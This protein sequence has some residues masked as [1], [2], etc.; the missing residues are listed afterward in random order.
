MSEPVALDPSTPRSK[1]TGRMTPLR[2]RNLAK[3]R[4]RAASPATKSVTKAEPLKL[5]KSESKEPASESSTALPKTLDSKAGNDTKPQLPD[6]RGAPSRLSSRR[7]QIVIQRLSAKKAGSTG[8]L[9]VD[10]DDGDD[11]KSRL[12]EADNKLQNGDVTSV[13][14]SA[15]LSS[16]DKLPRRDGDGPSEP[17]GPTYEGQDDGATDTTEA[18]EDTTASTDAQE[19]V[20][21]LDFRSVL[22]DPE[23]N[24]NVAIDPSWDANKVY[25]N[26][27]ETSRRE[28]EAAD[29]FFDPDVLDASNDAPIVGVSRAESKEEEKKEKDAFVTDD[30]VGVMAAPVVVVD[31]DALDPTGWPRAPEGLL[32][33]PPPDPF[34]RGTDNLADDVDDDD[35]NLLGAL[36]RSNDDTDEEGYPKDGEITPK[37]ARVAS[38]AVVEPDEASL[39]AQSDVDGEE[40][41]SVEENEDVGY[42]SQGDDES[43]DL[44][45]SE[46]SSAILEKLVRNVDTFEAVAEADVHK[47]P[48]F[49]VAALAA[50]DS[51]M[52]SDPSADEPRS[53]SKKGDDRILFSQN[54]DFARMVQSMDANS[55]TCSP[56]KVAG[57]SSSSHKADVQVHFPP[58]CDFARKITSLDDKTPKSSG[59]RVPPPPPPPGQSPTK[60]G[61][62]KRERKIGTAV[63]LIAPPSEEKLKRWEASQQRK[64]KGALTAKRAA[65]P[66]LETSAEVSRMPQQENSPTMSAAAAMRSSDKGEDTQRSSATVDAEPRQRGTPSKH[67]QPLNEPLTPVSAAVVMHDEKRAEKVDMAISAAASKFEELVSQSLSEEEVKPTIEELAAGAFCGWGNIDSTG[68]QDVGEAPSITSVNLR[69]MKETALPSLFEANLGYVSQSISVA[70][71]GSADL[72]E[73]LEMTA[74]PQPKG[75]FVVPEGHPS[76]FESTIESNPGILSTILSFL[77]DPVAVCRIKMTSKTCFDYVDKHEHVLIRDAVR[78][79]GMS[80]NVRPYFWLWVTLDKIEPESGEGHYMPLRS[81]EM[82]SKDL[83]ALE[84]VGREGKW[85]SVIERDVSRSFGNLPPHKTGARLRTDSIVR[86]LVTWGRNRMMKRGVRGSGEPPAC[87][88]VASVDSDDISLTPTDT[89]SDW[90]GVT[91]VGSFTS[92]DGADNEDLNKHIGK[93]KRHRR[94]MRQSELA[95]SG[96]TLTEEMKASLQGKLSFIL[97]A[98]A[99]AHSDVGYCQGM[100]YLVAHLLRILQDTIRWKASIGTLPR[101]IKSAPETFYGPDLNEQQR[102]EMFAE[103]DRSLVVEETCFRVMHAFFSNY[104]LRHFYWPEL[105]CLKTCCLVFERLIQIKLPVLA[106]HFEHHELNVGL[107]ALGW[108]QTLFLYL[109]S[110]PSA[111]VCH[112]WDIWLVE[113]SFKIF[114]RVGAAILF[115]SQPILLNQELEGMMSYLNTFPDATLLS[116]D[117]LIACALQIKVTNRMLMA[118]EEEVTAN[119]STFGGSPM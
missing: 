117:I 24:A 64:T 81:G 16:T 11:V 28:A 42:I 22:D 85:H 18:A 92:S 94:R 40:E 79:G 110:M 69:A 38:Y 21:G 51:E 31:D 102:Q 74:A 77:G 32:D 112:M 89:V 26:E 44:S 43:E 103:I 73:A 23:I 54:S 59:S 107:F 45:G 70:S 63:P 33:A 41:S 75:R 58:D 7:R 8:S 13:D 113:R 53:F 46:G 9:K 10:K 95:L 60:K 1:S 111:T 109:P 68:C 20:S 67:Q 106:D 105:R 100:D 27:F 116:P 118:L 98:L 87:S 49:D 114:F 12:F 6:M 34:H 37:E 93:P 83:V 56:H 14:D 65:A 3:S 72:V 4:A 78:L 91:P 48:T 84:N 66:T 76:P 55:P 52:A 25:F 62:R 86:A 115:L 15:A 50:L 47:V 5:S 108:F 88:A 82:A 71:V 104:Q 97:H 30:V 2:R 39:E 101:V 80:M 61:D 57:E 99:A 36:N 17:S 35:E 119:M 29:D 96:N 90:G 19:Q